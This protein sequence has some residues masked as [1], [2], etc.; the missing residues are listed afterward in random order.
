MEE[1]KPKYPYLGRNTFNGK[2]Y[3]VLFNDVDM[4][5]VVMNDTESPNIKFGAY[6]SFDESLFEVLPKEMYVTLSN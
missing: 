5:T 4:G 2:T 3:V 6:G 1:N